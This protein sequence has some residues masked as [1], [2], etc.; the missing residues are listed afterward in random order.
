MKKL[1][2]PKDKEMKVVL[3]SCVNLRV[4]YLA[5]FIEDYSVVIHSNRCI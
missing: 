5:I 2:F 4:D 3:T 1:S